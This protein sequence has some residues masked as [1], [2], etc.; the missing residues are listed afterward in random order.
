LIINLGGDARACDDDRQQPGEPH[1]IGIA[2]DMNI[3]VAER[4]P[5]SLHGPAS[6]TQ[7]DERAVTRLMLMQQ[8]PVGNL[9]REFD[10]CRVRSPI[11]RC[12]TTQPVFQHRQRLP[13]LRIGETLRGLRDITL[14]WE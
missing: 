5:I 9:Q 1:H 4:L 8:N 3:D 2:I 11:D 13:A 10:G 6:R 14:P 7:T 12:K